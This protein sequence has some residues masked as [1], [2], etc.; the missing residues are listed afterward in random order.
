MKDNYVII[1]GDFILKQEAKILIC[2]LAIQRGY[3]IFDFLK[4]LSNQPVFLD[5]H[6]DRFYFSASEMNL[7]IE[8]T[9]HIYTTDF[10]QKSAFN[11]DDQ[12]IS[13]YYS[14]SL[15]AR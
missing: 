12:I 9:E 11:A 6:F 15:A 3:G 5:D 13:I 1:N 8:V 4:T 10:Y 14:E 2:D 7:K